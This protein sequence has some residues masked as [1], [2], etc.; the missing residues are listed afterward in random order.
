MMCIFGKVFCTFDIRRNSCWCKRK[1][2]FESFRFEMKSKTLFF[3]L[4]FAYLFVILASPN[5]LS[6]GKAKAKKSFFPLHFAHLFVTLQ[7]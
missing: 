5:L 4:R 3:P 1:R 7:P 6:F 2:V